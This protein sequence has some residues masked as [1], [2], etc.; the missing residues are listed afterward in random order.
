MAINYRGTQ[1]FMSKEE[2]KKVLQVPTNATSKQIIFVFHRVIMDDRLY[3]GTDPAKIAA[4]KKLLLTMGLAYFS[5]IPYSALP[6]DDKMLLQSLEK[7]SQDNG[8]PHMIKGYAVG[9]AMI[10]IIFITLSVYNGGVSFG[11]FIVSIPIGTLVWGGSVYL[12]R[13]YINKHK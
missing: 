5:L 12:H 9:V 6:E 7:Y 4:M 10:F 1:N 13:T 8:T 2:A 3:T 11:V